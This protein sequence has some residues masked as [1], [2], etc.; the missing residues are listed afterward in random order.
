[1]SPEMQIFY[2]MTYFSHYIRYII[3][4][5]SDFL[6]PKVVYH[7]VLFYCQN[8]SDFFISANDLIAYNMTTFLTILS[9]FPQIVFFSSLF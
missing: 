5:N 6:S 1:M 8:N 9:F 3:S 4:H 7:N 2:S